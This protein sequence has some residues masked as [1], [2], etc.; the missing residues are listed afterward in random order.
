LDA[1]ID[2]IL[3]ADFQIGNGEV[4]I[5]ED[6]AAVPEPAS[7]AL[8][9]LGLAGFMVMRRCRRDLNTGRRIPG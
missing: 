7:I 6:A 5:T 9:G 4:I 3:V 8:L 2:Q 1:G